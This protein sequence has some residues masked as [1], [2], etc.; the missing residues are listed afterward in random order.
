[1]I[2]ISKKNAKWLAEH[3]LQAEDLFVLKIFNSDDT[4]VLQQYLTFKTPN[5]KLVYFQSLVRRGWLEM[6]VDIDEFSWDNYK[7]TEEAVKVI[8]Y[9][10]G[11]DVVK[12]VELVNL[13]SRDTTEIVLDN[14]VIVEEEK[15]TI[16][17]QFVEE[18][19][20]KW[21]EGRN[22][23]G[24]S[25]RGNKVDIKNKLIK[26]MNKYKFNKETIL[27]AA[28]SYLAPFKRKGFEYC[29]AAEY[30]ILKNQTSTLAGHCEMVLKN[31]TGIGSNANPF[32]QTM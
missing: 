31:G 27:S 19:R 18:F 23:G 20:N 5:Q 30:F 15:E 14:K 11:E 10:E 2:S 4:S 25:F 9:L 13:A 32:E 29:Q 8:E 26:F 28:D 3:N 24:V 22:G 16:F 21:P 17:D 6:L 12:N 7:L 1:V